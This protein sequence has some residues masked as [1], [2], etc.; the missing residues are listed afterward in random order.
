MTWCPKEAAEILIINF[1]HSLALGYVSHLRG[2]SSGWVEMV[3]YILLDPP[4]AFRVI[5]EMMGW[6]LDAPW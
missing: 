6:V 1:E 2:P 3:S 4:D 5:W